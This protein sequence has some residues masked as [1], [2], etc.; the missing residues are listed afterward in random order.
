MI[1]NILFII[2]YIFLPNLL[3][4]QYILYIF[5]IHSII[6][7]LDGIRYNNNII[8]SINTSVCIYFIYTAISNINLIN[9]S[10]TMQNTTYSYI[11]L[12]YIDI[13]VQI[14]CI[15]STFIMMG[16]EY[17]L[18]RSLPKIRIDIKEENIKYLY[19][20]ILF[21][22]IKD[23]FFQFDTS[24]L[25]SLSKLLELSGIFGI[26]FFSRLWIRENNSTYKTYTII[27]YVSTTIVALL[28]AFL[29]NAIITPTVVLIM[30][31]IIGRNDVKFLLGYQIIPFILIFYSFSIIFS[32]LGTHRGEQSN[33]TTITNVFSKVDD[34]ERNYKQIN[35]SDENSNEGSLFQRS[36]NLAPITQVVRLVNQNGFYGGSVTYP[37][38]LAFIPRFLYPEKPLVQLGAWFAYEAGIGYKNDVGRVNNSVGM[39]IPGQLYLDFGWL[40]V[41]LGSFLIGVIL[42]LLWNCTDFYGSNYNLTGTLFGGYLLVLALEGV[43][44]DLQIVITL[45]S[46]Y[47][48]FYFFKKIY[49]NSGN[50]SVM[51]RE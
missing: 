12:K 46:L 24:A 41:V 40:G 3:S 33:W 30:G 47:L 26:I 13:S 36:S 49:E 37:L 44:S 9:I 16:I 4:P 5:I 27:I 14:F 39:T 51:E 11:V 50:R 17:A 43:G 22:S 38:V 45:T 32:D 1:K 18:N 21:L 6:S 2:L 48:L 19:Y 42:S 10:G 7:L 31:M 28:Y 29:R 35:Y 20:I 15:S 34:K 8:I 23:L 25:G